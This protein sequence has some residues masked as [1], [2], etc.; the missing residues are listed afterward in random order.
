MRARIVEK[1]VPAAKVAVF[2]NWV[3]AAP[4][5]ADGSAEGFRAAHGLSD[6]SLVVYSGSM[7][8]KQGLELVLDVAACALEREDVRFL[9]AGDGPVR[10][11][12][13]S[14]ASRRGLANITFLPPQ[15]DEQYAALLAAADLCLLPQ[16]PEVRS[17]VMPSKVLRMLA[18]GVPIVAIADKESGLADVIRRSGGGTVMERRDAPDVWATV[19]NLIA[20]GE[21][22]ARMASAGRRYAATHFDRDAVL[23]AYL[24][25]LLTLT[26][27]R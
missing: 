21:A 16:R 15:S 12:L 11:E 23:T 17:L 10:K 18:G 25:R 26:R 27:D 14:A 3:D 22:R 6:K 8:V 1:G 9:L 2:P 19:R 5:N 24:D 13:A 7:G 4:P 20:D